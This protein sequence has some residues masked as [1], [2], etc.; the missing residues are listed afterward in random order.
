MVD[1]PKSWQSLIIDYISWAQL[2]S[3]K[4]P[5][6]HSSKIWHYLKENRL[7]CNHKDLYN[8]I[9]GNLVRKQFFNQLVMLVF[10]YFHIPLLLL[11]YIIKMCI[12][13]VSFWVSIF[14]NISMWTHI[15][16]LYFEWPHAVLINNKLVFLDL[17]TFEHLKNSIGFLLF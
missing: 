9:T 7:F 2:L 12:L 5:F 15:Y 4:V 11:Y 10:Y 8:C 3:F 17:N 6:L 1:S 14:L 16:H 13:S